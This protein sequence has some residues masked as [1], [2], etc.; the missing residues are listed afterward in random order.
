MKLT[1]RIE[2]V[3]LVAGVLGLGLAAA[4][5]QAAPVNLA[6]LA[7]VTAN[8]EYSAAFQARFVADGRIAELGGNNDEGNAWAVRGQTHRNGAELT[9][10][11]PQAVE[12]AQVVYYSRSSHAVEGWKDYELYV[13]GQAAPAVRGQFQSGHGPQAINLPATLKLRKLRLRFTNSFG[14][15]NP[16]ASEVQVWSAKQDDKALGRFIPLPPYRMD[17]GGPLP[18][19]APPVSRSPELEARAR[20]GELG[21]DRML[22]IHRHEVNPSHVYTYHAEGFRPGGGL[23][24]CDLADGKMTRLVDAGGGEIIDCELSYDAREVLFSW[25]RGGRDQSRYGPAD[26]SAEQTYHVYR[27]NVDG[28]G[29]T[30]L[31]HGDINNF[32]ACWLGD[33]GI[34]FLSDH[35]EAYAY[36]FT[37]TSPI[38]HRMDR[39]G[40]NVRRLSASYL[41]DFTP[42]VLNDGRIIY[43]RWEYVDRPACPIQSLWTMNPDGTAVAGFYGNRVLEPGTFMEARPIPGGDRVLCL[44][45]SHNGSCRGAIG[46]I[47]PALGANSQE[48]LRN[49]TPEIPI[50]RVD[51]GS[52]NALVNRGPYLNPFPLDEKHYLVSRRGTVLVRDYDASEEAALLGPQGGMGYFSPQPLRPRLRPPVIPSALPPREQAQPWATVLLQDVYAGLEPAVKRGEIKQIAVVQEVEKA[53]RIPL[54]DRVPTGHGYAANTA[55]GFQFPLVSCGATYAAKRLWGY[56]EVAEDGSACFK[57]PTGLPLYFL[58]LDAEGRAVQR[59][60]T[61]THFMPGETHSCVGCHA[62]RNYAAAR[63]MARPPA[64]IQPAELQRPEWGLMNFN[65]HDI[66]QPVLD[67]HCVKC[68][69]ARSHPKDVDLSGDKTDFFN[70]AYDVLARTGTDGQWRPEVHGGRQCEPTY[71][72]WIATI[73]GAESNVLQI[74]PRAWGAA[75]SK[76]TAIV[77]SGHPDKDGQPRVKLDTASRRRLMAWM[78]L[79]V[80]Y[81]GITRTNY[82]DRMGC[83]RLLP[84]EL[85]GAI[86][87]VAQRRCVSCHGQEKGGRVK[88]PRT[89]YTRITNPQDNTFLLAPLAKSAGGTQACGRA[90]FASTDDA[91]YKALLA[92]FE[93]TLK[94]LQTRPRMDFPGAMD[95]FTC[96]DLQA[97]RR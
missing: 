67:K 68:H 8:S 77:L 74:A 22:V 45:T 82:P 35:K 57:V 95:A 73:N 81:Y 90:V 7:R 48:A 23:Y 51:R 11:W 93:P 31:T 9:F 5:A 26:R 50:G 34:A 13:D 97:A 3:A 87:Q 21:F 89:F 85:D 42:A 63:A 39:D 78:D 88:I 40:G 79:N 66:V 30:Q 54:L 59:M 25:K 37:T 15:I 70:V 75:P 2:S 33:G 60:R 28:T 69:N 41:N 76:L 52:G 18:P 80:P 49:V 58:A 20:R 43:S 14:G 12:A 29:L 53:Q 44:L 94:M 36:C 27:I 24:I 38:L 83:R 91:D 1:R 92:V 84:P 71:V 64:G 61:F 19:T 72:R 10:E 55:F 86:Q 56:A 6:P 32:N 4:A 16:G 96:P 46:V 47:D 17:K 65:F 62:D